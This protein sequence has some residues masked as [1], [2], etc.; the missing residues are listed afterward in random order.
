M[1]NTSGKCLAILC[2]LALLTSFLSCQN[3]TSTAEGPERPYQPWVFR[4]VLD[5]KPRIITL[6]LHD[7]LWAAY[8]TDSCS[9]YKVWKG[10][11][12]LQGAVYD[13]AHGPQ[14]I[15]IGDSWIENTH[16]QPWSVKQG[17][18]QVLKEVT[19]GGHILKKGRA[20][21]I[22]H[23]LLNDGKTITVHEQPDFIATDDG[24]A[25]FERIFTVDDAGKDYEISIA[26]NVS[27]IALKRNVETNG[28][29]EVKDESKSD[30]KG[31][32]LLSLDGILTLK[33]DGETF[34][35]TRFINTPTIDNPNTLGED[36]KTLPLGERLIAKNDC[37]TCHN[38]MV[39]TIGPAYKQ[40]AERYPMQEEEVTRLANK[41][42]AGGAGI[43]GTQVMSAHPEL[44]KSD[45]MEMVRYILS[46]DITD[47][48]QKG[49][50]G[51][52]IALNTDVKEM[53]DV[54]PGLFVD[55]YTGQTGI[56]KIP[57][58]PASIKSNQ[59]GI[60]T[61]FQGLDATDFGGLTEDFVM[62]AK[63]YIYTDHDTT[64]GIRVLSDDGSKVHIDDQVVLDNDG[65]HGTEMKEATV[66]L[67]KGY[68]PV[69]LE[70]LQGKGGRYFSFEWK[71][72]GQADWSGIPATSFFHESSTHD[73]LQGKS[74]S[75]VT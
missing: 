36:E 49:E 14:P 21:L 74:L 68:H 2:S 54:L 13:N 58:Y 28:K 22:Y 18:Q 51:P 48:G 44:P 65:M 24:Q 6:A 41:V 32:Q 10:H 19:Y 25:G 1:I 29:W 16:K 15:S 69:K 57:S 60:V 50:A 9:L 53:K 20:L 38:A 37:K 55:V 40:I 11:V 62:I 63:G 27:S 42:I 4:S 52:A 59:A 39:Q 75:M 71:P 46:L 34:F 35:R 30:F 12:H 66:R 72:D 64:A 33:T 8:H 31:R 45:A 7:D 5:Q 70:Y 26:Q 17:G 61:E 3:K 23:L 73:Q 43:W 67:S 47:A 56:E